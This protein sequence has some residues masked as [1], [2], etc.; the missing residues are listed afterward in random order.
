MRKIGSFYSSE[1]NE[2]LRKSNDEILGIISKNEAS[3]D[4]TLQ[5]KNTWAEEIS[6]L[7]NQLSVFSK[8]RIIFEYVIPRMGK[9]IDVV[10]LLDGIV[11]LLE[12]KCG[13]DRYRASTYD[14]IYD[15]ALDLRN[16]HKESHDKL[17]VPIM[18][19][20]K[21]E[22]KAFDFK[23]KDK[24]AEPIKCNTTNISS[25][26]Q[27][28]TSLCK[29]APFDYLSWENSEYLPTPTIIE[30]A[31]ALYRGHNVD[32]ITRNDAG[33]K[34]LTLTTTEIMKLI[35]HSKSNQ[36]K[37]ICFITGIPGAGKTLVG[38]NV[39]IQRSNAGVG[40]HAVFL[41]GN[42][43]LVS[44]LQEA[45]A[46]DKVAQAKMENK[47]YRKRMPCAG[48]QRSYRLYISIVIPS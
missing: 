22:V 34:N 12:F 44:V 21:A 23:V 24:I 14:Q 43:P 29:E 9:R 4:T 47:K 20:T 15:Y 5:Q 40:E 19:S 16:F 13:D 31:Q 2:F 3:S 35:E 37:S 26:V 41:S 10:L 11:F 38:L 33:A 36:K 18:I 28:I 7:K 45:L 39:A 1:I 42:Y 30:A 17:L 27:H 46:R 25:R 6:I 48:H 8:A 32:D